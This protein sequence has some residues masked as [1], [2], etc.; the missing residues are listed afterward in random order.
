MNRRRNFAIPLLLAALLMSANLLLAEDGHEPININITVN[1]VTP[2]LAVQPIKDGAT[3]PP[4]N[5]VQVTVTPKRNAD[6][7]GSLLVTALGI[8][9]V[10]PS[11][12]ARSYLFTVGPN[13]KP[14]STSSFVTES[15]QVYTM[16]D[17]SKNKYK[18]SASCHGVSKNA[19]GFDTFEF[20]V[21]Y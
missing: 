10:A 19:F 21:S 8:P 11:V 14:T 12:I 16:N 15:I 9:G 6:C 20:D 1:N 5:Y 13:N 4:G 3:V 18:I 7:A 2:G 17:G